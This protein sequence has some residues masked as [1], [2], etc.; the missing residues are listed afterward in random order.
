MSLVMKQNVAANLVDVALLR[1]KRE[2]VTQA[3]LMLG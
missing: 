2:Y 1:T 3:I